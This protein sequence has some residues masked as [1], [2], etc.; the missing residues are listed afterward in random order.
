MSLVGT[1]AM[2]TASYTY[3]QQPGTQQQFLLYILA[4]G[5]TFWWLV[6]AEEA[7]FIATYN[8]MLCIMGS[9]LQM[10]MNL[11]GYE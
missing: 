7:I 10:C 4:T 9:Y 8:C 2:R 5:F 1:V 11:S 6:S 3:L